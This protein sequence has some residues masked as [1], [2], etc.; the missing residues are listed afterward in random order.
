MKLRSVIFLALYGALFILAGLL[1][2]C[3]FSEQILAQT[4]YHVTCRVPED[5]EAAD[6][7][8]TWQ[9]EYDNYR[10]V[11]TIFYELFRIS[12]KESL[13]FSSDGTYRQLFE[14]EEFDYESTNYEWELTL[15]KDEGPKLRMHDLKFFAHGVENIDTQMEL[16][17]QLGDLFRY[18]DIHLSGGRGDYDTEVDY[19]LDGYLY[20]YPRY[21]LGDPVLMQ[22]SSPDLF[23]PDSESVNNPVFARVD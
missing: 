17:A 19:P 5:L 7:I 10:S 8:G 15:D 14:S 11:D 20:L 1:Q 9:I 13:I 23:D 2:S 22:M 6:I 16:S 12:G 3:Q 18:Q 21:C 4:A